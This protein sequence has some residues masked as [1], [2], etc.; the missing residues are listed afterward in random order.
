MTDVVIN[1]QTPREVLVSALSDAFPEWLVVPV[2]NVPDSLDRPAIVIKQ[3]SIA[4]LPE[5]PQS[6]FTVS[7]LVTVVD[8]HTE[9]AN[10]EPSL[11]TNVL[12][13]WAA[14]MGTKNVHPKTATKALFNTQYLSY[15]IETD[16][17]VQKG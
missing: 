2:E 11:D 4:P 1:G 8:D 17:T 15:D 16:L 13:V 6:H 9:W 12:L 14:L 7:S 10:A 5:A 3:R